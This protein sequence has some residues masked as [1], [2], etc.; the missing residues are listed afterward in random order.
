[1]QST[2]QQ[3]LVEVLEDKCVNCHRCIGVC[4]VKMCNDGSGDYVKVNHDRCIGCGQCIDACVNNGV[5]VPPF[6]ELYHRCSHCS[7]DQKRG[8]RDMGGVS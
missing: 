5:G 2:A 4:P 6:P 3:P 8:N 7:Q 1:M